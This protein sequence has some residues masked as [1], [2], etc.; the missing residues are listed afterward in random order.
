MNGRS[1]RFSALVFAIML[2]LATG[3]ANGPSVTG[4][5]AATNVVLNGVQPTSGAV[6]SSPYQFTLSGY[7]AAT[8][9]DRLLSVAVSA[10]NQ[11]ATS[12]SFVGVALPMIGSSCY[13]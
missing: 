12:D 7:T 8:C 6:S 3:I 13:N 2:V 5:H 1:L 9:S 10:N 4:V 11:Y